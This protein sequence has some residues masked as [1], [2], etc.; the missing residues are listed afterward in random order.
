MLGRISLTVTLLFA[1][2]ASANSYERGYAQGLLDARFK[3]IR[4][5]VLSVMD[6]NAILR[7]R[8]CV[9]SRQRQALEQALMLERFNGFLP[10][11]QFFDTPLSFWGLGV[12]FD[13]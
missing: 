10:K 3:N 12:F 11:G 4:I 6:G 5:K 7:D 8:G 9:T 2:G 13:R 1:A